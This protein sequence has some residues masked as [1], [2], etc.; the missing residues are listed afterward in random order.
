[1]DDPFRGFHAAFV[2]A[3]LQ[4]TAASPA[5]V[6]SEQP[7]FAVYRNTVMAGCIDALASNYPTVY[8]LVGADCFQHVAKSFARTCPPSSGTLAHYGAE[9]PA[10]LGSLDIFTALTYLPGVATLDRFWTEAH[11][12]A[13][14]AVLQPADLAPLTPEQL[15]G[16]CLVP[17]PCT[18][19]AVFESVPA[20]TVWRRHREHLPL[21]DELDWRGEGAL[22]TRRGGVVTWTG[23]SS[24]AAAFLTSCSAGRSVASA[25]EEAAST[26]PVDDASVWLPELIRAG[27]F[28]RLIEV[29]T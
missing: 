29:A 26:R 14:A 6:L 5:A 21:D 2:R 17:H 12:S 13:D 27:A 11:L 22:L 20:Y 4:E 9:F 28:S 25:M 15:T 3:L 8:Q 1:M 18:R 16:S 23:I 10:F 7:G 24:D 19:W